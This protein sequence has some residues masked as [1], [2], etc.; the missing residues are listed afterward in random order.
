LDKKETI[1]GYKNLKIEI[2]VSKTRLKSYVKIQ[3]SEKCKGAINLQECFKNLFQRK[4]TKDFDEFS[5]ICESEENNVFAQ[6]KII[7]EFSRSPS[8]NYEIYKV[9]AYE[10][11]EMSIN[12]QAMMMLFIDGLSFID[13][14]PYWNYYL[15]F[16]K[17]PGKAQTLI[18][19]ATTYESH[20]RIDKYRT[21]ISQFFVL[22]IYQRKGYGQEILTAIY[23]DLH[24]DNS[25]FEITVEDP[26]DDFLAMR[27]IFDTKMIL[28]QGFFKCFEEILGKPD[29][30]TKSNFDKFI[31]TEAE[32]LQIAKKLKLTRIEVFFCC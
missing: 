20:Q 13:N 4:Y 27:D 23:K 2:L 3:Y 22:P 16:K 29:K 21:R 12:L 10:I 24:N 11:P 9:K 32:I 30:I 31:L 19:Y 1:Y 18:G 15:L 26:S 6:G 25:C 14:D 28:N 17:N 7:S 5:K 8:E